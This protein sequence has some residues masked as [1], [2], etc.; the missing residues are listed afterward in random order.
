MT[1][2]YYDHTVYPGN[3]APGSSRAARLEFAKIQEGFDKLPTLAGNAGKIVVVGSGNLTAGAGANAL[4]DFSLTSPANGHRLK[5]DGTNWVNEAGPTS[6]LVGLTD[7][8]TLT[9]KTISGA[10]NTLTNIGNASLTNSSVTIGST[11]IALGATAGSLAGLTNVTSTLF[12]GAIGTGT[13]AAGAFTTLTANGAFSLTGDQVQISE[14]GTG[15]TTAAAARVALLPS[16]TGNGGKVLAVNVGETDMEW[17]AVAGTGTVTSVSGT[18]TV[19][20]ITLSGTVTGAGNLTLSGS[21]TGISLTTGVTGTL[22]IANGGTGGTTASDARTALGLGTAAV[23]ADT[24]YNHRANNLSDVADAATARA[25]IGANN[26]ANLTTG[27][28][29]T[30]RLG[31]GTANSTTYLRGDGTWATVASG[32]MQTTGNF[33]RAADTLVFNDNVDIGWGTSSGEA[34]MRSDGNNLLINLLN[35]GMIIRDNT[36]TRF[37]FVRTTGVFTATGDVGK[38]SDMRLKRDITPINSAL[39]IVCAV[40]GVTYTRDDLNDGDLVHVGYVAQW[41]QNVLPHLVY[42]ADPENGYLAVKYQA[43]IPYLSE[44][45]K[46]LKAELDELRGRV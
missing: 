10:N 32:G 28:I 5:F 23:E 9:N 18:G 2:E 26:A 33:T 4:D 43:M 21:I 12:T 24:K 30:A 14:G 11:N 46:E 20:G 16:L 39:D 40:Q 19:N 1:G 13:P 44:A 37:T 29:P 3:S 41:L 17:L 38:S 45:I 7:T 27:T 36:T 8:Q 22:P 31:S 42:V 25:N 35:T 34:T 15:A 6:G